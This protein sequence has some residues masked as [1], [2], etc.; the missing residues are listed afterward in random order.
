MTGNEWID[1]EDKLQLN[2]LDPTFQQKVI[3]ILLMLF[4]HLLDV[5]G[6]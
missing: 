6:F 5:A 1:I 4:L 3:L 2:C